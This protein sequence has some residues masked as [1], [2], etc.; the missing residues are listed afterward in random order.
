MN[1]RIFLFI[2]A[3]IFTSACQNKVAKQ[4][5]I[6]TGKL[7]IYYER[8][9]SGSPV[10][11]LHAGLQDHTMWA[12]QVE[13]LR[14]KYELIMIDLP[15]QGSSFGYDTTITLAGILNTVLDQ[16]EIQKISVVG[17]SYGSSSAVDFTVA[18][19]D[20]VDKLVLVSPGLTGWETVLKPDSISAR[21][22]ALLD[23]AF[24]KQNDSVAAQLFTRV[25]CD[26]PFR[27]S[28]EVDTAVRNYILK[29][30][31][32]NLTKHDD[33]SWAVFSKVTGAESAHTIK[34]PTLIVYG[35]L[36]VPFIK[37]VSHFYDSI[38]QHST[39]VEIKNAAHMLNMEQKEVFNDTLIKFL[40]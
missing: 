14:S 17:L 31:F 29:T 3:V 11:L 33:D 30:T 23:S 20:R 32:A 38:I 2:F 12:A 34:N 37:T 28:T 40:D 15:A 10:L 35:N 16:L 5:F 4:G 18:H 1:T 27:K 21:Q 24:T 8:K 39:M 9:G 25:W 36:D 13:E 19:P 22:F 6:E 26:G 7:K